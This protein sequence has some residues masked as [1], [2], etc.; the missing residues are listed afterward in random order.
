MIRKIWQ[1][2]YI[3]EENFGLICFL[4][5]TVAQTLIWGRGKTVPT[6]LGMFSLCTRAFKHILETISV[7]LS[8]LC[9]MVHMN[10]GPSAIDHTSL[11]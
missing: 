1:S 5:L 4:Y 6:V 9:P 10:R 2:M 3:N 7:A 8:V 11:M